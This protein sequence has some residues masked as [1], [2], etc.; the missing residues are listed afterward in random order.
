MPKFDQHALVGFNAQLSLYGEPVVFVASDNRYSPTTVLAIV[1]DR[2]ETFT[3]EGYSTVLT[4]KAV[5]VISTGY[6]F[7]IDD[8]VE[9]LA[10]GEKFR[11]IRESMDVNVTSKFYLQEIK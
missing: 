1:S 8:S 2:Q 6:D 9:F 10:T 11:I 4:S 7:S 3:D 5:K